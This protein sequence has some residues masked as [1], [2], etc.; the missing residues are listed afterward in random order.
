[1]KNFLVVL[2]GLLILLSCNKNK[3]DSIESCVNGEQS[4][5]NDNNTTLNL[6]SQLW[7]L[8]RNN[9]G[10]GSIKLKISGTTNGDSA[11]IRTYGDGL[12]N[13]G[14]LELNSNKEFEKD[15]TISFTA[16]SLPPG[17]ITRS[18][19]IRVFKEQDTLQ[20]E[21]KSCILKY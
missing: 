2:F 3:D 7:Y 18:T 21:L 12:I 19:L 6:D 11:T 5:T 10:G 15:I 20:V 9:I 17:D 16:N 14:E 13:D 1:M 8:K 4:F